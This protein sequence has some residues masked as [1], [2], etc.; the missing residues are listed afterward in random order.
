MYCQGK[1]EV[2]QNHITFKMIIA[3][4]ISYHLYH[5][6]YP[7]QVLSQKRFPL[8]TKIDQDIWIMKSTN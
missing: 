2:T 1:T 6:K 3:K 7:F 5:E 8:P 4:I